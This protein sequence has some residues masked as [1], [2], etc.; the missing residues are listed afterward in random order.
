L[1]LETTHLA[2]IGALVYLANCTRPDITFANDLLAR[3]VPTKRHWD[4]V[5]HILKHREIRFVL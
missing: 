5:K 3:F 1:G 4:S 2:V